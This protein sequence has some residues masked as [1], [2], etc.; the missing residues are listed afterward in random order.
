MWGI[1]ERTDP[2][3]SAIQARIGGA[4]GVWYISASTDTT[5]P[6]HRDIW[7]EIKD[8]QLKF[9]PHDDDL[10]D[11]KFDDLRLSFEVLKY[12]KPLTSSTL[13]L[14]FIPILQ[15]R[16]VPMDKICD[17]IEH[18]L[19]FEREA[20]IQ[21]LRDPRSLRTWINSQYAFLDDNDRE[22]EIAWL[23]G[24]PFSL[25]EKVIILLEVRVD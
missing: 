5:S 7:I 3:P 2:I 8:S 15:D 18:Y 21:S 22:R 1:L 12:S 19:K 6:K 10:D 14:A 4:K 16:G 23:G 25:V 9:S 20:L 11:D 17:Q 24:L 13:N